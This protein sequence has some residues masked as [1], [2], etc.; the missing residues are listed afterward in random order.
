MPLINNPDDPLKTVAF[1][2]YQRRGYMGYSMRT[3]R[4]RSPNGQRATTRPCTGTTRAIWL[5]W[6]WMVTTL[7][8][9]RTPPGHSTKTTQMIGKS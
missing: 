3:D 1:S 5:A 2:K 6:N 7:I 8:L 9:K 4:F